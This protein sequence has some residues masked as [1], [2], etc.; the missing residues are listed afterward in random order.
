MGWIVGLSVGR[1]VGLMVG[2]S[3]G[4]SVGSTEGISVGPTVGDIVGLNVGNEQV[5]EYEYSFQGKDVVTRSSSG[6]EVS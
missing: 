5:P 1:N 4:E 2:W 6:Q 3:V